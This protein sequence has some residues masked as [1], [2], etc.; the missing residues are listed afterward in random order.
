[1][2]TL[3]ALAVLTTSLFAWSYGSFAYMAGATSHPGVVYA[4][5]DCKDGETWNEET[6]ACEAAD[7][8]N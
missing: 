7:A 4:K 3:T 6:K 8:G 5:E 1:M 2:K